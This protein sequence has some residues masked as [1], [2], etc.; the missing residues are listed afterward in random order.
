MGLGYRVHVHGLK[1]I[2]GL[3]LSQPQI[4]TPRRVP[5]LPRNYRLRWRFDYVNRPTRRGIWDGVGPEGGVESAWRQPKDG[6]IAALIEGECM[7]THEV[8][9]LAEVRGQDYAFAQWDSH[10]RTGPGIG[11]KRDFKPF[12]MTHGLA[13]LTRDERVTVFIDGTVARRPLTD[14]ERGFNFYEHRAGT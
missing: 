4:A 1:S 14:E 8:Y 5:I 9:V 7:K 10:V 11:L 6:L 12:R 13:L 3:K 2:K